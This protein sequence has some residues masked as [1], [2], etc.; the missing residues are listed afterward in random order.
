[1]SRVSDAAERVEEYLRQFTKQTSVDTSMIHS[2]YTDPDAEAATLLTDDLSLLVECAQWLLMAGSADL[3]R[4]YATTTES[5]GLEGPHL[6]PTELDI[7]ER[8]VEHWNRLSRRRDEGFVAQ[9]LVSEW[10]RRPQ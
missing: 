2:V 9:R 4:E 8:D 1:L 6:H 5:Q 3:K 10:E 7:A